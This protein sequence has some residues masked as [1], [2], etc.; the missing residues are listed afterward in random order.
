MKNTHSMSRRAFLVRSGWLAGGITVLGSCSYIPVFPTLQMGDEEDALSWI[1]LTR[2]GDILFYCPRAEMGQGID[3]GLTLVVAEEL[4]IDPDSIHCVLP[5][6]NQILPTKNTV[7]SQSIQ[8]YFE[9][10]ALAAATL[11]EALRRTAA[12]QMNTVPETLAL[13]G[14]GFADP[15]GNMITYRQ[16]AAQLDE[17]VVL[18][19]FPDPRP[20]L[21]SLSHR[22]YIGGASP[23]RDIKPIVH[24]EPVFVRDVSVEGM[25]FGTVAKPPHIGA[26]LLEFDREAALA[27]SGVEAVITGPDDLPGIVAVTPM[28]L[29][30]GMAALSCRWSVL[31]E[32]DEEFIHPDLD[33]DRAIAA[34]SLRHTELDHQTANH[35]PAEGKTLSLRFDTPMMAHAAMEPRSGIVSV[36]DDGCEVW[37]ASQDPFYIQRAIAKLLGFKVDQVVVQNHRLGGAFGGRIVCQAALE[38]AW[39]SAAVSRPVKVQWTREEEF[40]YNYAGP[41]FSHR[42][43][44][45]MDDDNRIR[46]WQHQFV[47]SPITVPRS[48]IPK[49]TH[50]IL[51]M[52][53]DMGVAR[54]SIAPYDFET[55]LV[56]YDAST[57]GMT[58]GAWRGLGSAPN[59]FAVEC[60]MDE[61]AILA[62]EDPITFRLKHITDDRLRNV[63][64][65][66]RQLSDWSGRTHPGVA[67]TI[68][69]SATYVAVVAETAI[70]DGT[71]TVTKLW[72]AQDCGLAVSPDRIRAQI[73]GNLIWAVSMVLLEEFT[74]ERGI[75]SS[76]NFDRYQI[77]RQQHIPEIHIEIVEST[78]PPTGAGEPSLAPAVAAIANGF[79]RVTGQRVHKLPVRHPNRVV[80]S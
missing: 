31:T 60:A 28:A 16:I 52:V 72:C 25:L 48:L 33:I 43:L 36:H 13:T 54:G 74:M 50:R 58:T 12:G 75:A 39:L 27:I 3:T 34:D 62:G 66:V 80:T 46:R 35:P 8:D 78:A 45:D 73:E 2:S 17:T 55:Q 10:T 57:I 1:Q 51:D 76:N 24:G 64:Q 70:R 69:K 77:A 21:R 26:D 56:E 11:R 42:I 53:R 9:P 20:V 30:L 63:L 15:K 59:A 67:A 19:E 23:M 44:I 37:A 29:R 4:R 18:T 79:S 41:Q 22:N 65:R 40:S 32:E 14:N 61:A 71:P 5:P 7:G 49:P 47:A 68:Y 6:T 38:A